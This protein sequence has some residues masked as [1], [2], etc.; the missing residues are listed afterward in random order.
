MPV[1]K[2]NNVFMLEFSGTS[3]GLRDAKTG[4]SPSG[5]RRPPA[6]GRGAAASTSNN[7]LWFAEYAANAIAMLDTE[8]REDQG[9]GAAQQMR[10]AL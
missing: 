1:D 8:D 2:H 9:V 4:P 5:R 7:R 3:I 6:R 10:L